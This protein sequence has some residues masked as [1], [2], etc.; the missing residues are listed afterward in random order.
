VAHSAS[1]QQTHGPQ[2]HTEGHGHPP[3]TIRQYVLIGVFLTVVTAVEL[4][5]SYSPFADGIIIALL[6]VLS[7]VKFATVVALFMHLKFE[8][9]LFTRV[10]VFGIVLAGAIM[11]ALL[12]LFAYD[13][14]DTVPGRGG[15]GASSPGHGAVIAEAPDRTL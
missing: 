5:I 4:W 9:P 12:A 3:T 8:H 7:A 1:A 6:F 13:R 14:T 10:F 2:A 11:L 15:S